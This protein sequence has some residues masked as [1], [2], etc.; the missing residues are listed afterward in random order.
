MSFPIISLFIIDSLLLIFLSIA[1]NISI[2][3]IRFWDFDSVDGKQ[4]KLQKKVYLSSVI[5]SY[6]IAL[7]VILFFMFL[8]AI[9]DL[10][11]VITGA[12]CSIGVLLNTD[13]GFLTLGLKFIV[14]I[15]CF[16]WLLLFKK[17]Q[18]NKVLAFTKK[19]YKFFVLV[20][21][22]NLFEFILF[23]IMIFSLKTDKIVSCCSTF[24]SQNSANG[25]SQ[26]LFSI[27]NK[28]IFIAFML[29]FFLTFI[30][31]KYFTA[32]FGIVFFLISLMAITSFFSPYIYELP[33]HKCPFCILQ[34]DYYYIGYLIYTL[35]A[36]SLFYSIANL[37]LS[38]TSG[39]QNTKF[40]FYIQISNLGLVSIL[41]FYICKYYLLNGVLL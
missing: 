25:F 32:L 24:F 30:K 28:Y 27:D 31:N 37:F 36:A 15:L 38:F 40:Y 35:V 9:D 22:F 1:L 4:Y 10:S 33:S 12:M 19:L 5:L 11:N 20:Y 7:K 39:I 13:Y 26:V 21:L 14:I 17:N 8:Y 16:L 29:S 34:R 6:V 18:E 2:E 41:L 3:I 23:T